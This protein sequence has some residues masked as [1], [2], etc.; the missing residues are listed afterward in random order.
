VT[1]LDTGT[2]DDVPNS[3]KRFR[4]RVIY[5]DF[6]PGAEDNCKQSQPDYCAVEIPQVAPKARPGSATLFGIRE[7]DTNLPRKSPSRLAF[8]RAVRN[9]HAPGE[10]FDIRI[11]NVRVYQAPRWGVVVAWRP[12]EVPLP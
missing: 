11:F 5:N 10:V 7:S 8:S 9:P 4:R 12:P 3:C 6:A 2:A 1:K